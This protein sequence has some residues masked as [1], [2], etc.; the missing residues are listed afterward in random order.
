MSFSYDAFVPDTIARAEWS[1]STPTIALLDEATRAVTKLDVTVGGAMV[2]SVSRL[3]LRAESIAS[4]RIEGLV[5]GNRRLAEALFD[6]SLGNNTARSVLANVRAMETG[7]EEAAHGPITVELLCHLHGMLLAEAPKEDY[8]GQLRPGPVWLGGRLPNPMDADYIAPPSAMV[9]DLMAD[10]VAFC[11]REDM[12]ALAQAAIA[13]A[14]FETIHPFADGNG[15]AGRCLIHMVMQRRGLVD[16]LAPPVSQILAANGKSYIGGLV[17]YREGKAD[18]WCEAFA[19]AVSTA[20]ERTTGLAEVFQQLRREWEEKIAPERRDAA[21]YLLLDQLPSTPVIDVDRAASLLGRARSAV[22]PAIEKLEAA[23]I[24]S[25]TREGARRGRVWAARD[26]FAVL[27][28]F[29]WTLATPSQPDAPRQPSPRPHTG[30][31]FAS[32]RK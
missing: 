24:L 17:S 9:P 23:G 10:L 13:H 32:E 12:P 7:L 31:G 22:S 14:Q 6:P 16:R 30:R 21:V 29:E 27:D 2:E 1:F 8:P 26:V 19:G 3:L 11:Q 5:V 4:S 28:G 15:R 25:P 20:C 18:D